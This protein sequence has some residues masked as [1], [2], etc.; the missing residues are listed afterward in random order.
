MSTRSA[1]MESDIAIGRAE[2]KRKGTERGGTERK[3]KDAT[4][5]HAGTEIHTQT[6]YLVECVVTLC[7]KGV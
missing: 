1:V 6:T 3:R 7:M 5:P 4:N 2:R